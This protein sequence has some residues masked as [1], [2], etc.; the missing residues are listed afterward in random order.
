MGLTCSTYV[1]QVFQSFGHQLVDVE[2]WETRDTDLAWQNG[3]LETIAQYVSSDR[4]AEAAKYI[5]STRIRPEEAAAA[6]IHALPP[7]TVKDA[8]AMAQEIPELLEAA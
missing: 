1:I 8:K 2:T 6:V 5:G 3:M 4:A 7:L